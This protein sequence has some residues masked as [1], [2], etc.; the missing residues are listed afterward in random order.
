MLREQARAPPLSHL[1]RGAITTS[2]E[3]PLLTLL[4]FARIFLIKNAAALRKFINLSDDGGG[5]R[6]QR[7]LSLTANFHF[8]DLPATNQETF[9]QPMSQCTP[10]C[11]QM[12][13]RC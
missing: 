11:V 9:A 1:R 2:S 6:R 5:A 13:F 4:G 8:G 7:P 12:V 10:G 3:P